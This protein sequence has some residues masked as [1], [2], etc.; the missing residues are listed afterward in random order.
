VTFFAY[1][2][3]QGPDDACLDTTERI[4]FGHEFGRLLTA[5]ELIELSVRPGHRIGSHGLSHVESRRH[6]PQARMHGLSMCKAEL[7]RLLGTTVDM[8]AYPNG[9]CDLAT[10]LTAEEAGFTVACTLDPDPVTADSDPLR[11]P[12]VQVLADDV[13]SLRWLLD[14]TI[15]GPA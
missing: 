7:G 6:S 5:E 14:R 13:E 10:T 3:S 1:A 2:P 4:V 9:A 12:R 11:L 8:L 15:A